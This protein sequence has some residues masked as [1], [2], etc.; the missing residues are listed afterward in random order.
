MTRDPHSETQAARAVYDR[1]V[2]P[3]EHEHVGEYALV[4]PD[5]QTIFAPTLVD[6]MVRAHEQPNAEN[7]IYKVGDI[8]LG[9][10]R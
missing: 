5:G 4:T 8:V 3:I 10:L 2:K 9:K 7:A 1:H 6:I